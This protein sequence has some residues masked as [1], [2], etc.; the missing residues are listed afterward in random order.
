MPF[1][2]TFSPDDPDYDPDIK[3]KLRSEESI[4]YLIRIGIEALKR[5]L[6]R[7][8]FTVSESMQKELKE[9][10]QNN[11]PVLLFFADDPKIIDEPT[12]VVY[13][14][15][16]EFCGING[17]QPVSN[18]EFSRQVRKQYKVDIAVRKIRGTCYKVFVK[19]EGD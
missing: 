13:R 11:N 6:D 18:I 2:A 4:R 3:Y 8:R 14:H 19:R 7:K 17:F 5:V 10:E 15:Y 12:G 9:Y 16:S 1:R